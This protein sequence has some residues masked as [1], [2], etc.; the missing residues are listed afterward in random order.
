MALTFPFTITQAGLDA[1]VNAQSGQTDPIRVAQVG[2]SGQA[3]AVSPTIEVLP[4]EIKRI[5]TISGTSASENIIHMTAT[6]YSQDVYDVQAIGLY[7]D[8]GTLFAVFSHAPG[9]VIRKVD[10]AFALIAFDIVFSEVVAGNISF[11]DATF[12]YPPATHATKGV[13]ELATQEEVDQ[14]LDDERIVTALKLAVRLGPVLQAIADESGARADGDAAL[15]QL[16]DALAART[17]TGGGLVTGGGD[18]TDSRVLAVA[19]AT[20]AEALAGTRNDVALTPASLGPFKSSFAQTDWF[21]LPGGLMI[22]WGRFTAAA[23]A[24]TAV[25]FPLAFPTA[26]FSVVA[27]GTSVLDEASQDNP[28]VVVTSTITLTGFSVFASDNE[29]SGASYIAVGY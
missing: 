3:V 6:D 18:L 20:I 8:D 28:P 12:L 27:G 24:S 19:A 9:P 13:A 17:V 1:L 4:G 23:N 7:L 29:S 2:L 25:T 16:I 22:Q 15:Q 14:G 5:D 26:C 11:G 21:R 10:I